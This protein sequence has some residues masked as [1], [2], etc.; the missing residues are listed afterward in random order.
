MQN[1][2]HFKRPFLFLLQS[3]EQTLDKG[4]NLVNYT[5]ITLI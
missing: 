2:V 4:L 5:A 1:N 3:T